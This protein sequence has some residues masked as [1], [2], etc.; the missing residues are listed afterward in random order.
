VTFI[1][2]TTSSS[3]QGVYG[4]SIGPLRAPLDRRPIRGPDQ[5]AIQETSVRFLIMVS[6]T[7]DSS[8]TE[9]EVAVRRVA[10]AQQDFYRHIEASKTVSFQLLRQDVETS[11]EPY[12][13]IE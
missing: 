12:T 9:P 7:S 1:A 5:R 8:P 10:S 6:Q 2:T 3:I 13:R 11:P 4:K